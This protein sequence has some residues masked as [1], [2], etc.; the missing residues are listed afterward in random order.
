MEDDL[1]LA[2]R[3]A[4]NEASAEEALIERLYRPVYLAMRHLSWSREDAEDLTQQAFVLA[5]QNIRQYRGKSSLKTWVMKIAYRE[6]L[7][8]RKP[9]MP[10]PS[11]REAVND[12]G[13]QDFETA[14]WLMEILSVL[15]AKQRE[16]FVLVEV[17]GLSIRDVAKVMGVPTGTVKTRC[18]HARRALQ[19]KIEEEEQLVK[20]VI[21]IQES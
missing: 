9:R 2:K 5:K 17:E 18:F 12:P 19:K 21:R 3:I 14:A 16:A 11:Q 8:G 6:Y 15:P 10:E 13:Y 4:S 1:Q 20:N 7:R